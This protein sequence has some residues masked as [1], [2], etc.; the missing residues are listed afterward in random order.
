MGTVFP[1][2]RVLNET[3]HTATIAEPGRKVRVFRKSDISIS[4]R[5][6]SPLFDTKKYRAN[7]T[8]ADFA[9]CKTLDGYARY[10][11][12]KR[13]RIYKEKQMLKRLE[14]KR[15]AKSAA[16]KSPAKKPRTSKPVDTPEATKLQKQRK[17]PA[18]RKNK[19]AAPEQEYLVHSSD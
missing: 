6:I 2:T 3:P 11:R 7:R 17:P 13:N 8:L 18:L 4:P 9:A 19:V 15:S 16:K 5:P 14:S 1:N 12:E 10:A